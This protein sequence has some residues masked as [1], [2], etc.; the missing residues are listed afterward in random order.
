MYDMAAFPG[1]SLFFG[2]FIFVLA[3]IHN[4]ANGRFGGW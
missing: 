2:Y 1:N 3:V 4:P